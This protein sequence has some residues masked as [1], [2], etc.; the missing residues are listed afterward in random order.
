MIDLF[1]LGGG[2]LGL[3]YAAVAASRGAAVACVTRA[4][5][6]ATARVQ[7]GEVTIHTSLVSPA[8]ARV[9]LV[10]TKA[11]A[12]RTAAAAHDVLLKAS[13]AVVVT[14][15]GIDLWLPEHRE[16]TRAIAWGCA[17][18]VGGVSIWR[19]PARLALRDLPCAHVVEALLAGPEV[20]VDI[21]S[22][23]QHAVWEIEKL[24]VNASLNPLCALAGLT[25]GALIEDGFLRA[26]AVA[27]AA[28]VAALSEA[29]RDAE[30]VVLNAARGMGDF[31]PS[32]LQDVRA[33]SPLETEALVGNARRALARR[34]LP[35]AALDR[36]E[37]EIGAH[38]LGGREPL[39]RVDSWTGE[40]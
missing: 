28:E 29:V 31:P 26:R 21:V 10:S 20:A 11:W 6:L 18:R 39:D 25:P 34:G 7:I 9:T 12:T 3:G 8:P 33:G 37:R 2:A 40:T 4:G 24:M 17:E 14:Q 36:L 16:V 15:N 1:V 30:L 38:E 19:G 13:E 23:D 27:V 35:H 22:R 32:M 5:A